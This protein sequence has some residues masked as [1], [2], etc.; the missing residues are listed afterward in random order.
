M[1]VNPAPTV[2]TLQT[3]GLAVL[4][5]LQQLTFAV[6]SRA[7]LLEAGL[8]VNDSALHGLGTGTG[9]PTVGMSGDASFA[10]PIL[11]PPGTGGLTPRVALRYR[12]ANRRI[13]GPLGAGWS[14]DIGPHVV[15]RSTRNGAPEYDDDL[16]RFELG[17]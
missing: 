10:I 6:P 14:L 7:N 15:E 4:L 17:V 13:A 8:A 1:S 2:R 12:S 16:D 3:R 9:L 5:V 11:T